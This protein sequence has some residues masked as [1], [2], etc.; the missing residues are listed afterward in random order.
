MR[1]MG[2]GRATVVLHPAEADADAK[3]PE[4]AVPND[5]GRVAVREGE[6]LHLDAVQD[7][8]LASFQIQPFENGS[9]RVAYDPDQKG[10]LL[11]GAPQ[12]EASKRHAGHAL[13]Q[14]CDAVFS[15]SLQDGPMAASMVMSRFWLG[16]LMASTSW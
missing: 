9:R 4:D 10:V 8:R 13:D 1:R 15:S 11:R 7:G 5:Q 6:L 16:L 14:D 12:A 2:V 3:I